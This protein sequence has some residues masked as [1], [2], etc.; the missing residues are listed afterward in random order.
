[1]GRSPV[2]RLGERMQLLRRLEALLQRG[3]SCAEIAH[4]LPVASRGGDA[5]LLEG[6]LGLLTLAG[7]APVARFG[8]ERREQLSRAKQVE[9]AE[10]PVALRPAHPQPTHPRH[11]L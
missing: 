7:R 11:L 6:A 9:V 4:A 8:V 5:R 3:S 2:D 10:D 1:D